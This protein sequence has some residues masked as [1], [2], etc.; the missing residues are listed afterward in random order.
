M[1][2]ISSN[3]LADTLNIVQ[4]A[5]E[6]ALQ[7]G[8]KAQAERL[9]SVAGPLK[10]LVSSNQESKPSAS[11]TGVMAQNDFK[12]LLAAAASAGSPAVASSAAASG[13]ERNKVVAAM[14]EGGMSDLDI[15]RQMGMTRE[16]IK[17]ILNVHQKERKA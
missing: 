5:R 2:R 3:L 7:N 13:M 6:S 8:K 17:L 9:N 12:A 14:A 10:S 1:S 16:E 4:L 15:A 11:P